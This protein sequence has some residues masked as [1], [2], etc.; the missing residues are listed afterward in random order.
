M[1]FH[2]FSNQ[3]SMFDHTAVSAPIRSHWKK[4]SNPGI[5]AT[6]SGSSRTG[7]STATHLS[8]KSGFSA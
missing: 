1:I 6:R 2:C 7:R 3:T 8:D 4:N 5:Q